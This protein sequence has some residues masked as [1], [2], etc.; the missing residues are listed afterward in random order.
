MSTLRSNVTPVG[1]KAASSG[2]SALAN[3]ANA[4]SAGQ[5]ANFS[6]GSPTWAHGST[7]LEWV[8]VTMYYDAVRKQ[9]QV[10]SQVHSAVGTDPE[11]YVFS[12]STNT[13]GTKTSGSIPNFANHMWNTTFDWTRGEYYFNDAYGNTPWRYIPGTGW[14]Q[15]ASG[16]WASGTGDTPAGFGWHPNL[17]GAGD[18]GIVVVVYRTSYA[19]RRQTNTWTAALQTT[20]PYA[21]YNGGC[22]AYDASTD[23]VL[24][25][26]GNGSSGGARR[27]VRVAAGSGGTVGAVTGL[28]T[29]PIEITASG[30]GS[31]VGKM[32]AHPYTAGKLI[33]LASNASTVWTSTDTGST[34]TTAGT[35]PFAPGWAGG[36][37]PTQWTCGAI[38]RDGSG[39]Y[40]VIWGLSP[41]GQ[42]MLWKPNA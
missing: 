1:I 24:V 38:P 19:W 29:Q 22:G 5:S 17:F 21:G 23:R 18:G 10:A 12:E 42:S 11:H 8:S 27:L 28:T 4:L 35:H 32:M 36:G 30:A 25:G 15:I 16:P 31:N 37:D 20:Q 6:G 7:S 34:W 14:A 2:G 3:A 39:N 40:G 26:T 13:W 9:A 33:I 41:S